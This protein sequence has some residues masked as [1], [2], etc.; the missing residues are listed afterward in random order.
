MNSKELTKLNSRSLSLC[1]RIIPWACY[2]KNIH[3]VETP[4]VMIIGSKLSTRVMLLNMIFFIFWALAVQVSPSFILSLHCFNCYTLSTS[5][6]FH[7]FVIVSVR[8]HTI[9]SQNSYFPLFPPVSYTSLLCLLPATLLII[10][11]FRLLH[12]WL[13]FLHFLSKL[14]QLCKT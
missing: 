1:S 10:Q 2:E 11:V 5:H 8:L 14:F 6:Q 12:Q 4:A 9:L 3:I 13:F 7:I